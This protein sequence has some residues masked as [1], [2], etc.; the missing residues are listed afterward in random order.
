LFESLVELR[1]F[2]VS[3]CPPPLGLASGKAADY[4][5]G[6]RFAQSAGAALDRAL[7]RL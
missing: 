3:L 7:T 5:G 2:C 6:F 1:G 4:T